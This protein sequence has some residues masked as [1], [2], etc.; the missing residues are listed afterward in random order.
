MKNKNKIDSK[1]VNKTRE[2]E[3]SVELVSSTTHE[4]GAELVGSGAPD[5]GVDLVVSREPKMV[6]LTMHNHYNM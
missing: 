2:C 4:F 1:N 5:F 3:F 6:R